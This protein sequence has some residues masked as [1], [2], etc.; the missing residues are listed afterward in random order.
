MF[1]FFQT[2][3]SKFELTEISENKT[4]WLF[5]FS[6]LEYITKILLITFF[7]WG[8]YIILTSGNNTD[9]I[10]QNFYDLLVKSFSKKEFRI[11]L[12][13]YILSYGFNFYFSKKK[14]KYIEDIDKIIDNYSEKL[15]IYQMKKQMF[16]NYLNS[17]DLI[18]NVS[19]IQKNLKQI[20]EIISNDLTKFLGNILFSVVIIFLISPEQKTKIIF[21]SVGSFVLI[22]LFIMFLKYYLIYNNL[23]ERIFYSNRVENSRKFNLGE[24]NIVTFDKN[25]KIFEKFIN[26]TIYILFVIVLLP[27]AFLIISENE[28]KTAAYLILCSLYLWSDIN[29]FSSI[30]KIVSKSVENESLGKNFDKFYLKSNENLTEVTIEKSNIKNT[31]DIY[32]NKIK[33]DKTNSPFFIS[34]NKKTTTIKKLIGIDLNHN[35]NILWNKEKVRFLNIYDKIIYINPE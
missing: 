15:L 19:L 6:F 23:E 9:S 32:Q 20:S 14:K 5:S 1:I 2:K 21:F 30:A 17:K 13:I 27:S 26:E 8:N 29:N 31:T 24:K 10:T 22:S 34:G 28:K 11:C 4:Y 7:L 12:A 35:W 33:I 16:F 25:Y 18:L 3:A